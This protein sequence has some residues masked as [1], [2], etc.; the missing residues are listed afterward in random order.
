VMRHEQHAANVEDH[1]IRGRGVLG[2]E[3]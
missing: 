1:S 3:S 2:R